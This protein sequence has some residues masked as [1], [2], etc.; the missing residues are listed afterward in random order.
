MITVYTDQTNRSN[1]PEKSLERIS[2]N[3]DKIR[4]DTRNAEDFP[5]LSNMIYFRIKE[6]VKL[7]IN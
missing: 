5:L 4:L 7:N 6:D 3:L 2:V 1:V